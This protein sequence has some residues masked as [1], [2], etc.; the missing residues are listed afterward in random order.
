MSTM[1]NSIPWMTPT[2]EDHNN[3]ENQ[4]ARWIK[5]YGNSA[6]NALL[7]EQCRYFR[8]PDIDGVLGYKVYYMH[9]VMLGDPVCAKEDIKLMITAFK[10]YCA[11]QGWGVTYTVIGRELADC[12]RDQGLALIEFGVEQIINP[13]QVRGSRGYIRDVRKKLKRARKS[14]LIVEEY[15][16]ISSPPSIELELDQIAEKWLRH[17]RGLQTYWSGISLFKARAITRWFYGTVAGRVVCLLTLIRIEADKG[18]L[19]EHILWHPEAPV[20]TSETLITE[21]AAQL[22]G[23]GCDYLSFGPAPATRLGEVSGFSAFKRWAC[24]PLY[25]GCC[26]L[27]KLDAKMLF[28]QK[29]RPDSA[30]PLYLA[31]DSPELGW[32][33]LMALARTFH[34]S[35][36]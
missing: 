22:S 16:P 12:L 33:R 31:F 1:A 24:G 35:R 36:A 30:E 7:D 25:R 14:G 34:F 26:R 32:R 13:Q 8:L 21:V 15:K 29:F 4:I 17:R 2:S 28:R 20:G 3:K 11:S 5:K 10:Q 27:F 9:A 19:I 6:S 23:E 18:Y